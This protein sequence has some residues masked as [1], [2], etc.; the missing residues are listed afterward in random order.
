MFGNLL[1]IAARVIPQQSVTWYQFTE[2]E[3]DELGRWNNQYAE[4][5]LITGSWQAVDVQDVLEMGLD[6]SKIY[7]QLY[8]SNPVSGVNRGSSPDYLVS[9]GKRYEVVGDADWYTQD[10]WK[11]LVCM[12][13]GNDDG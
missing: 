5:V 8:T 10:G 9:G 3:T 7:R 11:G 13:A 12:E 2:R 4:P 1:N 6:T